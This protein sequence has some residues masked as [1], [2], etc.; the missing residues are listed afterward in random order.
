MITL[1]GENIFLRALEP[2]DL[3]FIH[4]IEND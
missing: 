1:K 2:E 3:E 4:T